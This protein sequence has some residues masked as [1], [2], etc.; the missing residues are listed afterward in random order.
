MANQNENIVA[1][2]KQ[3]ESL[4]KRAKCEGDPLKC[5]PSVFVSQSGTDE[6]RIKCTREGGKPCSVMPIFIQTEE[7][8]TS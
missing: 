6:M 3:Y 2:D 7:A 4:K 5:L 1:A 8:A